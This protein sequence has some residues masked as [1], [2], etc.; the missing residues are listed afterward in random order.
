VLGSLA[1]ED[2]GRSAHQ[3]TTDAAHVRPAPNAAMRT[4]SPSLI[5]P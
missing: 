5:L 1:W 4:T 3:R 2:E